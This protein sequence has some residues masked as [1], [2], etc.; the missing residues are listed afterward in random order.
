MGL[1]IDDDD[2]M[3][4]ATGNNTISVAQLSADGFSEVKHQQVF[5]TPS[6][7]SGP[8]EGSHFYKIDGSY[9]IFSTQYANGEYVLKSTIGPFG[10]YEMR[11]FAVQIPANVPGAG[12]PHQ[13]GIVQTQ[14]GDWYYLGFLD[15]YPGGRI[16]VMAP[17]SW[18]NDGWPSVQLDN[19]KWATSY[20][21]P[22]VPCGAGRVKPLT[23]I[24]TFDSAELGPEWEW[25]HNPDNSKWSAGGKLTLQTATVTDDLYAAR[26]TLTHRILGPTSTATI[27]LDYGSMQDGDVAGLALLRDS[28]AWIGVK[29][30]SAGDR[31]AM[32]DDVKMDGSWNSASK[33]SEVA[34]TSVSGGKIWLRIQAD[35]HPGA[36]SQARFSYSTD[37]STFSDLGTP[38]TMVNSWQFFMGYRFAMFNY[39]TKSLGGSVDVRSFELATP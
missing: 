22:N 19:G 15:A 20:P 6:D 21:F 27:E 31:V 8:L 25:N 5:Q 14:N 10:P 28:S 13:G 16:P 11:P 30:T 9:Y 39:A 29:H 4:V 24:D 33:G 26:N 3:Y 18:D 1:L 12:H 34:G 23:G 35:I 32:V 36:N 7:L 2:T 17:M 37:G 38:F